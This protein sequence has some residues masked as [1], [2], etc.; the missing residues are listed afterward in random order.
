MSRIVPIRPMLALA[1]VFNLAGACL[2][3]WPDSW[4][5]QLAG[6]P[7]EVPLI[8]RVLVALFVLLFG[9]SYAWLAMQP[10]PHR[11]LLAFGAL[12]KTL[13]FCAVLALW[14]QS[15]LPAISVAVTSGDLALAGLF[16]LWLLQTRSS[17][18]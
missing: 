14:W 6:L 15:E 11:P 8:Y 10:Q 7:A 2:F 13:A 3:A 16:A 17:A 9:A 18:V 5:G 12:G 4:A 1:A